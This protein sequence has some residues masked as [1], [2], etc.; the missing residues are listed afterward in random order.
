[1]KGGTSVVTDAVD[2]LEKATEVI[3]KWVGL[4]FRTGTEKDSWWSTLHKEW[5]WLL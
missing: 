1:M 2:M 4:V 3:K 5:K